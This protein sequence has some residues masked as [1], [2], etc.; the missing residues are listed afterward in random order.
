VKFVIEQGKKSSQIIPL[1]AEP[2]SDDAAGAARFASKPGPYQLS[3][4]RGNLSA[5]VGGQEIS[6][7]FGGGR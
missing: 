5:K 7:P 4:I 6:T 3:A 2:K 1:S